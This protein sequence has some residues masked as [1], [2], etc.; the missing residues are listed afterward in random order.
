MLDYGAGNDDYLTDYS[1][2]GVNLTERMERMFDVDIAD[3]V[4]A[5]VLYMGNGT[6]SLWGF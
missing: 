5:E 4:A 3:D 1:E 6:D 2:D